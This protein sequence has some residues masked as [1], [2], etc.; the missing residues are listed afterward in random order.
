M[1]RAVLYGSEPLYEIKKGIGTYEET[2]GALPQ[3]EAGTIEQGWD[4]AKVK[5]DS[6]IS[7]DLSRSKVQ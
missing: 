1:A 7:Q 3:V 4:E 2:G 5:M 6:F